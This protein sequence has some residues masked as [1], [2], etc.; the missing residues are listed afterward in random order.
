[1]DVQSLLRHR[2][3]IFKVEFYDPVDGGGRSTRGV[4]FS[5]D[6]LAH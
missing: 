3:G 4:L 2:S 1:M 5:D 6:I